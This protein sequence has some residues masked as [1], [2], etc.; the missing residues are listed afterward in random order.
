[1]STFCTGIDEAGFGPLLGPLAIVAVSAR[2]TD[3]DSLIAAFQRAP[4]GV[5][6]SKQ[7]Y[8][9]GDLA[10]LESVAL[11]AIHWLTGTM[12]ATA[13][14]CFALL[15]EPPSEREAWP[16]LAGAEDLTLPHRARDV[17]TWRLPGIEPVAVDG[18]LLHPHRLNQELDQGVNRAAAELRR[19]QAL[20]GRLPAC[21][22]MDS[23][24]DR[25]G[26]RRYYAEALG[27][28]WPQHRVAVLEEQPHASRYRIESADGAHHEIAFLVDGESAWPLTAV[29]S[30]IAKYTRELHMAL[31]NGYWCRR[32]RSIKPTAGYPQDARRWLHQIG[33]GHLAAYGEAL[34][35]RS[36]RNALTT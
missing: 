28:I 5:C 34:V 12:P 19:V 13:A 8:R 23:R 20:L 27:E 35:R 24:V 10:P 4:L 14:D 15:G 7:L 9:S 11:A 36:E 21:A 18:A 25:L 32:L 6:D 26:G 29:A 3:G 16:W 31:L 17:P 33:E 1:M 30:C 22:C 2:A